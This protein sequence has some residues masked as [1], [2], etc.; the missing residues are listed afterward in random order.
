MYYMKHIFFSMPI[1]VV[2]IKLVN[3][4]LVQLESFTAI[5]VKVQIYIFR[6]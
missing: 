2:D 6:V 3:L 4:Q 5:S 1:A